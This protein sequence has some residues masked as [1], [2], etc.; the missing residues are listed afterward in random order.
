MAASSA[1]QWTAPCLVPRSDLGSCV[2]PAVHIPRTAAIPGVVRVALHR[3]M[4]GAGVFSLNLAQRSRRR[5]MPA[6]P[7]S[8]VAPSGSAHGSRQAAETRLIGPAGQFWL[9]A[10]RDPGAAGHADPKGH[11]GSGTLFPGEA[12]T[13]HAPRRSPA[14]RDRASPDTVLIRWSRIGGPRAK[15]GAQHPAFYL[16]SAGEPRPME[17]IPAPN[18]SVVNGSR[19]V[20]VLRLEIPLRSYCPDGNRLGLI[21]PGCMGALQANSMRALGRRLSVASP[22]TSGGLGAAAGIAIAR[23]IGKRPG[24]LDSAHCATSSKPRFQP[25]TRCAMRVVWRPIGSGGLA[26]Q[27]GPSFSASGLSQQACMGWAS[28]SV[29]DSSCNQSLG[30]G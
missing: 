8:S 2:T 13:I 3:S 20:G 22:L 9:P 16:A 7:S 14:I 4:G 30:A 25:L 12:A 21:P 28:G 5:A 17:T 26:E 18:W 11:G 15:R 24:T 23:M 10:P 6:A 29:S 1:R 19:V 27:P